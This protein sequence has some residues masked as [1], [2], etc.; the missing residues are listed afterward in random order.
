MNI[1]RSEP[2][3]AGGVAVALLTLLAARFLTGAEAA[4]AGTLL[5]IVA[6]V[7]V[8]QQVY[9]PATVAKLLSPPPGP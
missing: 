7:F 3:L 4:T 5:P 1:L 2:A 6:A 8:R 9:S